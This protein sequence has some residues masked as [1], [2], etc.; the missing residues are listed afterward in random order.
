MEVTIKITMDSSLERHPVI[1]LTGGKR[2]SQ[3]REDLAKVIQA[4]EE[5]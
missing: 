2:D 4:T 3:E 1:H 5:P